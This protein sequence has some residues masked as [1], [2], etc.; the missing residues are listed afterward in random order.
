[1]P[2]RS[3]VRRSGRFA[4][5]SGR[6]PAAQ[7][8]FCSMRSVP[9]G[10]PRRRIVPFRQSQ[11]AHPYYT[12]NPLSRQGAGSK[13]TARGDEFFWRMRQNAPGGA[14]SRETNPTIGGGEAPAGRRRTPPSARRA[15]VS[16]VQ[17][18]SAGS[19]T[20]TG[21]AEHSGG[22]SEQYPKKDSHLK[23][24]NIMNLSRTPYRDSRFQ[25]V[26]PH[27][28]SASHTETPHPSPLVTASS[29]REVFRRASEPACATRRCRCTAYDFSLRRSRLIRAG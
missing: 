3:A 20:N 17:R 26:F 13:K 16:V 25:T 8:S 27:C 22:K 15:A 18:A 10:R 9:L 7:A 2:R 11:K 6:W 28:R 23:M 1:M 14:R 12:Q 5:R 21:S 4:R 24:I 29:Q 19:F